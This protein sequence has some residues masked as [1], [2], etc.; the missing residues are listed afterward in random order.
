MIDNYHLP[1]K[2][3][4]FHLIILHGH[5]WGGRFEMAG[6]GERV[7]P[8]PE[9]AGRKNFA[10]GSVALL[11]ADLACRGQLQ[12]KTHPLTSPQKGKSTAL[13]AAHSAATATEGATQG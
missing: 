11:L 7:V 1:R 12:P 5:L 13:R 8:T 2:N 9:T 10:R 4:S 3:S 6:V